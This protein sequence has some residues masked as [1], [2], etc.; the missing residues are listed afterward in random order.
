[1]NEPALQ[2]KRLLPSRTVGLDYGIARI[3][4]ALSDE[5]KIIAS[6]F[7]TLQ[8]KKKIEQTALMVVEE[9]KAIENKLLCTIQEIVI[10]IPL[11]MSG[12]KGMMA[13]EVIQFV[14]VLKAMVSCPIHTWDERLTSV[15]ADRSL[16][17]SSLTRKRRSKVIDTVTAAIILQNFLDS[18][19]Q[20]YLP[21]E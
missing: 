3:G 19:L 13:D 4:V 1:M 21:N 14:D 10:G 6:P 12:E 18:R 8:T 20:D 2:K 11:R 9:L 5:R 17:E 16:R 15:Q 7:S